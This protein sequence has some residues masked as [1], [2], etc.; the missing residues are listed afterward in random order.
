[1]Q[2]LEQFELLP[3]LLLL[4]LPRP[5]RVPTETGSARTHDRSNPPFSSLTFCGD[6]QQ[7]AVLFCFAQRRIDSIGSSSY[8][9]LYV[10]SKPESNRT[11]Y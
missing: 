11:R 8:T 7:G 3:L 10:D 2:H 6:A 5:C 1:M 9:V 4:P